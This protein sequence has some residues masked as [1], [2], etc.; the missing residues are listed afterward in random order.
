MAGLLILMLLLGFGFLLVWAG[1]FIKW[2]GTKNEVKTVD[3]WN[4][5][6]DFGEE[7]KNDVYDLK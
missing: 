6:R 5:F 2:L 4:K 1:D 7:N 3:G